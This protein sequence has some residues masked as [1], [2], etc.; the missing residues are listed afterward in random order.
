MTK[1]Q[2]I[3]AL[4]GIVIVILVT[5]WAT[6][7]V[8]DFLPSGAGSVS[9]DTEPVLLSTIDLQ[10]ELNRRYP[11]LKLEEDGVYGVLTEAAH[12]RAI[13]DQY[14]KELWPEDAKWSSE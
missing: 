12:V 1:F 8:H 14:A 9:H 4:L 7:E 6:L 5:R 11:D 2:S 3:K 10:R 13:G